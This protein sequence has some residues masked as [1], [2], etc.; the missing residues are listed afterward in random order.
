MAIKARIR[1]CFKEPLVHFLLAGFAVFLFFLW[2][3]ESADPDSRKIK[4]DEAH[5]ARLAAQFEQARARPPSAREIDGLIR[6]SIKEEIYYREALRLGLDMD[7]VIIRRRLRSKMEFLARS[8]L[9]NIRP[10][11]DILQEIL[12]ENPAKYGD[13]PIVDFD[14]LYM[15]ERQSETAIAAL[16]ENLN[17]TNYSDQN[18]RKLAQK[19]A[20]PQ[21]MENAA[22]GDIAR[23]FGDDF[24]LIL[25]QQNRGEYA[26]WTGPVR[27]G[28]GLHLVRIQNVKIAKKPQLDDIRQ[29]L[30]NDWRA[31]TAK[32]RE[33][34]AYQALLDAYDIRIEKP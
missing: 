29:R 5:V 7:D 21:S 27:S 11:N 32:Q 13:D 3:G 15:G 10:N 1:G 26:K 22:M 6:D 16:L 34:Q 8:E 9:E 24:A 20:L 25:S 30:E 18:W 28:F 12:D 19:I 2:R 31:A 14:Q 23:K 33:A 17:N 4:I